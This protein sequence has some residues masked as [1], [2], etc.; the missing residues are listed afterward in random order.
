MTTPAR[1]RYTG[2]R[3]PAEIIGHAV[4]DYWKPGRPYLDGIEYTII[5]DLSTRTL[6]FVAGK[7]DLLYG[8][9][10]P[11]IKDIKSQAPQVSDLFHFAT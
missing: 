1:A 6:A 11:Q 9:T 8:V 7:G 5:K 10:T 2:Y 4:S 3:F